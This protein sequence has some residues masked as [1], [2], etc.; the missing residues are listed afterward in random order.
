MLHELLDL[1]ACLF[2]SR[3]VDARTTYERKLEVL[4]HN[5]YGV[6][7]DLFA[8][9]IARLRLWLSLVVDYEDGKP[10]PLPNLD[11]KI[12]AGD[13]LMA[14]DP[15]GRSGLDMFRQ[16]QIRRYHP[17]K[18]SYLRANHGEKMSL[19]SEIDQLRDAIARWARPRGQVEGFDW[20]VKLAEIFADE[21]FDI[22]VMNPPYVSANRIPGSQRA[23]FQRYMR[24]LR[25]RFGFSSDLYVHFLYRGIQLLKS[26]GSLY[27]ITSNT[28]LT[29][30]TKE[31]LRRHLL[32]HS[33][34]L[35]MP[36]G[37]DIFGAVVYSG[38]LGV[39]RDRQEGVDY[40]VSFLNGRDLTV[41]EVESAGALRSQA[42]SIPA[43]EYERSFA[44]IFFEPTEANR[45]LFS[46]LLSANGI[47]SFGERRFAPVK[48]VAPALDTGIDTGN[49][50]RKLF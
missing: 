21:G 13:S 7:V 18:E 49:V 47:V 50:R 12:E 39:R 30:T 34:R 29:N 27:A 37:P 48:R 35:L 46:N 44:G 17:L 41:Q 9:N 38:I 40:E 14:P 19:R 24:E 4:Q 10:P 11:L 22:V 42:P 2:V 28:Y 6:D 32:Q 25:P 36:L 31:H 23:A 20:A 8:V 3:Q 26:G 1:R 45:R 16:D 15:S 33:L 5:L 43:S